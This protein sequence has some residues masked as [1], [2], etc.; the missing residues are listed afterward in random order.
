MISSR[1]LDGLPDIPGFRRLTRALAM[2]D[3][4]LSPEWEGRYYSFDSQWAPGEM[5]A[6]M[7]NGQGDNWFAWLGDGG[8]VLIGLDHE[9]PMFRYGNPWPGMFD[10]M[11]AELAHAIDE[12]AFE[13][14]HSTFCIWRRTH[15][16]AW[17]R[18]PV[19]FTNGDDP[20]GSAHLLRHLDANPET[21]RDFAVEYYERDV[22]L[23]AVSAIYRH[24]PLTPALIT[25][26][27]DELT[28][29]DLESD[30]VSIGY[31]DSSQ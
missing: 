25:T 1:H 26:L 13:A 2:L 20:D 28:L 18:G 11:P 14:Q 27:N 5:M 23:D 24:A 12:P 29:D 10:G 15:G 16:S 4:I 22:D 9:A 3:A 31:P 6:S 19:E 17:E 8:V 7:R 21:Y 30:R